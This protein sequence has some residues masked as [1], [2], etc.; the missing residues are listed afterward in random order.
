MRPRAALAA[1]P[2]RAQKHAIV[3]GSWFRARLAN[4]EVIVF[5]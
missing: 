4:Q 1:T 2:R 5:H 3:S